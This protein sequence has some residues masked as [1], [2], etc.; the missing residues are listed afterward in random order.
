MFHTPMVG[1]TTVPHGEP[2]EYHNSASTLENGSSSFFPDNAFCH[3]ALL[4]KFVVSI[5]KFEED[6]GLASA[7]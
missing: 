4:G 6:I 7:L 1:L 3:A 5:F 2:A